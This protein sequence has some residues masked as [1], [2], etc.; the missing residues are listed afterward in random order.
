MPF[1]RITHARDALS[2]DQ[3]AALLQGAQDAVVAIEGEAM[4]IGVGVVIEEA[5]L[6][7]ALALNC[8]PFIS[9]TLVRDA[10]TAAQRTEMASRLVE[11][12]VE[13]E[14]EARRGQIWVVIEE[15]VASG[16]WSIGGNPLTLEA[17]A[18]IKRGEN[19]WA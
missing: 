10:L 8:L 6:D 15:S 9:V 11:A 3:K 12:V 7:R 16:E 19:P 18:A 4:R 14:G 1:V 17:L 13:V 2:A 5:I